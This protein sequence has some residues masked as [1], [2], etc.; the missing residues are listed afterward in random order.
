MLKLWGRASSSNVMKVLWLLEELG[1]PY[2]RVDIGGPFG[3]TRDAAYL[4]KNPNARVPTIEEPDG[5]TLWES[6]SI[7]RYLVAT[8]AP[9][10]PLHPAAPRARADVE[11]WMDWHLANMNPVM[12]TL[13]LG[14]VQTP[15]PK[16]DPA[17]LARATADAAA[18][19]TMLDRQLAGRS[20]V[21]G[22]FSLAD[23]ALGPVLHRWF[24]LPLD[25]PDLPG[26]AAYYARLKAGHAGFATHVA[27][28]LG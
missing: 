4:A 18:L 28:P 14:L 2:E 21:A 1:V 27:V 12:A 20:Y 11:R 24:A 22:D 16:R 3:G 9:G 6:H 19:W 5:Y 7:L 25:R 8:R 23:I 10:S 26:L 15:E 17:A 13:F